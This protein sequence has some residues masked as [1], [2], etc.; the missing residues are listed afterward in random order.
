MIPL[1]LEQLAEVVGG[2]L[3][4]GGD[5]A[6]VADRVVIDSRLAGPGALFVALP[7]EHADGH[8]FAADAAGRGAAGCLADEARG[9][10]GVPGTVLVDDPADALLGLGAWMRDE[11]NPAV[12]AVTGSNGKTTT[13]DLIAAAAGATLRVIANEGSFN[14][15]LG[16]PLTCCRLEADTQVLVS[17]I[18]ARGVGHIASLTPLVRPD[19]SVVTTVSGA[20]LELF[21][22]VE[23]VARA[24]G[25]LVEALG[26]DG[27]AVLNADDPRVAAMRGKSLGRLVTYGLAA[28]A[29]W[30]AEHLEADDLARWSFTVRGRRVTCPLPG[31]HNVGNALAALAVADVLGVPLEDAAA[32]LERATVS[33]W[34]MEL[35]RTPQGA[36]VL[37]DA[38][39][40]NP[41][42]MEAA[43]KTLATMRAA[44]RRWAVLGRMAELGEGEAEAHDRIGR[45]CIRLGVDGLI[46]VGAQARAIRD[47][48]DQEGFYGQGDLFLADDADEAAEILAGRLG[49]G[50]VVL[51]KASRSAG[52]ERVAD[53][54]APHGKDA[55]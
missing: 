25:E 5:A 19:V 9:P 51:V 15:E 30:R 13:K 48:A 11:V 4:D 18:G 6:R 43:L 2:R 55:A 40:A 1:T 46:V 33:H 29:D 47:A 38:Y 14:N 39:N 7:G 24:K 54:L 20:H 41:A 8:D 26:P 37:N 12:V 32:A 49:A 36:T 22:D 44:G 31:E 23:T 50:D 10:V 16:V 17:E 35:R 27:V 3:E 21:K 42:S 45:L 53:L 52:L 34:R 28:D